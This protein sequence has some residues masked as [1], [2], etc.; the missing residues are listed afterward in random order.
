[1]SNTKR[2]DQSKKFIDSA[3]ELEADESEDAFERSLRRIA[4]QKP[5]QEK[6]TSDK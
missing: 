5:K 1:M 3:R 6:E 2:T 4:E